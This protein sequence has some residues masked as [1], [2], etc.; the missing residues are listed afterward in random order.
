VIVNNQIGFTT[1]PEEARSSDYATAVGKMLQ[2]PIFHINGE[3]P[4]DIAW[5]IKATL[6]DPMK[7]KNWGENGRRRVIEYF[8]WQKVA[9]ETIKIYESLQK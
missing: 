2:I 5:C 6:R 7:A 1:L 8:T 3:D 9:E 4:A